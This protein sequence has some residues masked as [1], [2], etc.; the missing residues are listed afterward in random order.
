MA[1]E[2]L[3]TLSACCSNQFSTSRLRAAQRPKLECPCF[4]SEGRAGPSRVPP[5][6]GLDGGGG[7]GGGGGGILGGASRH[8]L[9]GSC[10]VGAR[11]GREPI[12]PL[13][14]AVR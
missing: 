3:F 4:A 11:G 12:G 1:F 8:G 14:M 9:E 6:G 13:S 10:C 7:G 2:L 5:L